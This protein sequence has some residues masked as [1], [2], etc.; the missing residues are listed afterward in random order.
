[1][2]PASSKLPALPPTARDCSSS[3][4]SALP[5]L[6]EPVGGAEPGGPAAED[7]DARRVMS[8]GSRARGDLRRGAPRQDDPDEPADEAADEQDGL[9]RERRRD[10]DRFGDAERLREPE[11][12][13][14]ADAEPAEADRDHRDE[15]RRAAR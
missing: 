11:E 3:V 8:C 4:T 13:G 15:L 7:H 1:M 12:R 10:R 14:L 5:V 9:P 6:R 2:S